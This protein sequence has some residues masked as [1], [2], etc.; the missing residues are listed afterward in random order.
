MY[1]A[2]NDSSVYSVNSKNGNVIWRYETSQMIESTPFLEKGTLFFGSDDSCLYVLNEKDGI[3][4]QKFKA[5]GHIVTNVKC[6]N[7]LIFFGG[8]D[9]SFY[10]FNTLSGNL[11]WKT[12]L[13]EWI[14]HSHILFNG[15]IYA[16]CENTIVGLD[17]K[18]GKIVNSTTLKKKENIATSFLLDNDNIYFG[19][20]DFT[21]NRFNIKT[22]ENKR[23]SVSDTQLCVFAPMISKDYVII[24]KAHGQVICYDKKSEKPLWEYYA[25]DEAFTPFLHKETIYFISRDSN[26]YAVNVKTG[27][28][29]WHENLGVAADS[30]AVFD[31]DVF[32]FSGK[33]G[34]IYAY[35]IKEW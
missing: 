11:E 1:F 9:S 5:T 28:G 22:K 30:P 16:P 7:N 18:N 24:A 29:I 4:K 10:C 25:K 14:Y 32:Y 12:K 33:D 31:G 23:L 2:S 35:R 21:F 20:F 17:S 13:S 27:K 6:L 3:L 8:T 34:K 19:T 26:L 15:T